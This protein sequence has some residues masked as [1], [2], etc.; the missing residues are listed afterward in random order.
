MKYEFYFGNNYNE[1]VLNDIIKIVKTHVDVGAIIEL[2][3]DTIDEISREFWMVTFKAFM[4]EEFNIEIV[5]NYMSRIVTF[6][7]KEV[8][9]WC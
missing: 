1:A 5:T 8:Q 3:Y 2:S 4:V 6:Y 9:L 7:P